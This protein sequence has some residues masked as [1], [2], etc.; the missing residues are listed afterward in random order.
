MA[1]IQLEDKGADLITSYLK[2]SL[3]NLFNKRKLLIA[4]CN[5]L[6]EP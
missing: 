4:A 6:K 2:L 3:L 1:K 5:L